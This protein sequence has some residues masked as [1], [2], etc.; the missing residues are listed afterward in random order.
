MTSAFGEA[1]AVRPGEELDWDNLAIYL[2]RHLDTDG[3]LDVLQFPNGSANLTY[4]L[5]LG[6]QQLVFRRPPF[7]AL[8]PG[9]HDMKREYRVLSRLWRAYPRAPRALLFCDDHSVVGADFLVSEYRTGEMVWATL[10]PSMVAV[11]DAGRHVGFAAVEALADLSTVDPASCDLAEL[12]R[13]DGFVRRQVQGWTARWERVASPDADQLMTHAGQLLAQRLPQ[14]QRVSI[15]HNDFK[16]DNCQYVTGDPTQVG[17]VFDWDMATL[18]DPLVD[19]GILLNYWPDP[20][21]TPDDRALHYEGLERLGLPTRAEVTERYGART[22][23]ETTEIGW[24]EAFACW[25]TAT[26]LEQLYYRWRTGETTD[27]RM[28]ERHEHVVMLARRAVRLLTAA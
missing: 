17:S 7:G 1:V 21:D 2:R 23:L 16:I 13:P 4:L 24:Y 6:D 9:A 8:A 14:P 3:D 27:P 19:L 15:L 20:A 25:K 10:P 5:R 26:V 12:G 22:G 18:G 28:G 11:A